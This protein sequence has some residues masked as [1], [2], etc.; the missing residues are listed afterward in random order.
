VDVQAALAAASRGGIIGSELMLEHVHPNAEGYFRLA[1]AYFSPVVQQLGAPQVDVDDETARREWPITEVDRLRGEYS[2]AVL[3]NDWPFVPAPQPTNIPAAANRIE[4]IAQGWFAGRLSWADAMSE[5][6][7]EYQRA[8]N[9]REASR[10]AVNLADAFV[11]SADAQYKA[12]VWLLRADDAARG[13]HYLRKA[14]ALD[15]STIEYRLSLAQ[16][17]FMLGRPSDS[18]AT[19]EGILKEHPGESRAE[20]W[21][22]EVRRRTQGP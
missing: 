7:A 14:V 3:R 8:G 2:V 15:G 17:Q 4:E 12:G 9:N 10:V 21:I 16:A 6:L 13:L 22:G 1:S 19:L 18:I 11:T 5:A 20:Y